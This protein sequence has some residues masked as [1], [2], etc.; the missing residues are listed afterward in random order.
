MGEKKKSKNKGVYTALM[1]VCVVIFLF[2]LYNVV[3][4]LM[5]YK[6]V[7]DYYNITIEE[8]VETDDNGVINHIDLAKLVAKNQD[9]KGWIY[10]DGTEISYPLLQG[11]DNEFYLSR[12]YEK[13]WLFAGSIYIDA[14]NKSDLTDAHTIIYG[15]NMHNGSMFG[16]LD[17]YSKESYRN[18]HPY[19]Y[20]MRLDGKWDKY[21]IFSAYIA[22]IDD[23]TFSYFTTTGD[24]YDRYLELTKTK[25]YYSTTTYPQN[26]ERILTL[27]TCTEDSDDFKRF[28]VH[29]KFVGTVGSIK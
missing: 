17:K 22:D 26:G 19:I 6:E 24:S 27:S 7:E 16:Q 25:N 18:E 3:T 4:I 14:I 10:L 20:I 29:S 21:E 28:V 9:V 8:Y 11:P 13:E 23:G 2:A 5:D 12:T 15:H 1:L